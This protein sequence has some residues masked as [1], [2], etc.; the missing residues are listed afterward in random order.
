MIVMGGIVG[1][2]IFINPYV[3]AQRVH[4]SWL[5]MGAWIAGGVVALLGAFIYAELADRMPRVGGQ[6]AYLREAY[7][8]ALGF[9]YGW[10]LLLVIQSGGMAAVT[11]TFARYFLALS[12]LSLPDWQIA[13][14][15]LL[16]LTVINCMGVR[17][18]GSVQS[19][20]MVLKIIAI[21]LLVL[22][23]GLLIR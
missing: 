9:L 6:Y 15:T 12:G 23:G 5:I 20:L 1:S 17:A 4:T 14:V 22:V 13:V 8:P 16:I 3:V 10:V 21:A 18:G 2:G 7:H 19:A 11:I